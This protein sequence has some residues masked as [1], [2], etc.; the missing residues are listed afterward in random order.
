[1]NDPQSDE[2]VEL[3]GRDG[4]GENML[5]LAVLAR[6]LSIG[7]GAVEAGLGDVDTV[8]LLGW[9]AMIRSMRED[10]PQMADRARKMG[11]E[12]QARAAV[13]ADQG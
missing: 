5:A 2:L 6:N 11:A 8:E 7:Q 13:T 1:M 4:V 10:K 3:L 9:F 12:I